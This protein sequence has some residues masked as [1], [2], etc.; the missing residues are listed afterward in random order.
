MTLAA[1]DYLP[2]FSGLVVAF[3]GFSA[4]VVTVRRALEAQTCGFTSTF[5]LA[6]TWL[7]V[8][9]GWVFLR[10]ICDS[11]FSEDRRAG[12]EY[13][14]PPV[15]QGISPNKVKIL[16]APASCFQGRTSRVPSAKLLS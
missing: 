15:R 5:A 6:V 2:R 12:P 1:T 10:K 8:L 4:V 16:R 3:V 11:S 13:V 14:S 7:P 9:G